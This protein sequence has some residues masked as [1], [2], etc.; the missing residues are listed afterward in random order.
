MALLYIGV[1]DGG[2]AVENGDYQFLAHDKGKAWGKYSSYRSR[3]QK[4]RR[5]D[6]ME[7]H[8][9]IRLQKIKM[10]LGEIYAYGFR[11]RIALP[12]VRKMGDDRIQCGSMRILNRSILL[13]RGMIMGGR[14]SE[15]S[16]LVNPYGDLEKNLFTSG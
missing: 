15:G 7:F 4:Q 1:G 3:W 11:N 10:R 8:K 16:F 9:Q 13:S 14:Y 5:M 12:G 6:S 2:L